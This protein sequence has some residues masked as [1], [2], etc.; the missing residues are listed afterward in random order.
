M[1]GCF[2]SSKER[3][4]SGLSRFP[5]AWEKT[6]ET[7]KTRLHSSRGVG[8]LPKSFFQVAID[9]PGYGRSPGGMDSADVGWIH[10]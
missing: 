10:R 5:L 3:L 8:D 9:C 7:A 4:G 1:I 6:R 2:F